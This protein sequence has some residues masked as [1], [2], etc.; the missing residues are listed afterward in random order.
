M[1]AAYGLIYGV[2]FNDGKYPLKTKEDKRIYRTWYNVLIRC[3][4]E[5]YLAIKPTYSGCTVSE[6]FKSYSYFYEWYSRQKGF[7]NIDEKGKAWH[8]D[9]DILIKG[10]KLYGEA[11]CVLVPSRVN[12]LLTSC[13]GRRG[14]LPVGV[15]F[16]V[17]ANR[18]RSSCWK[19]GKN[20]KIG[21]YT[22]K[23]EAFL[24]YKTFKEALIK[25]VAK[26]YKDQLDPRAYEALMNYE[27]NID[28]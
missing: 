12:I 7:K 20:K 6:N 25:Q 5:N 3:Y 13:K 15:S 28:D 14:L 1:S 23:E 16:D 9:K 24:A 10:N 8:L 27:V 21:R 11:T 26:A 2:G 19:N 17:A 22:S 18:F 4:D